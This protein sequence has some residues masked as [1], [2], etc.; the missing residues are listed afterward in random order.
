MIKLGN[1]K[2]DLYKGS[3]LI[4]KAY[5]GT[6]LIYNRTN[7]IELEY[8]E[9]TGT[10]F[11]DTG[12]T[13]SPS[14]GFWGEAEAR[15]TDGS[16]ETLAGY[17]TFFLPFAVVPSS[18]RVCMGYGD[19]TNAPTLYPLTDG[20]LITSTET[21]GVSSSLFIKYSGRF[22]VGLN[23]KGSKVWHFEDEKINFEIDLPTV[24]PVD[25]EHTMTVF[26]RKYDNNITTR[27]MWRG[28]I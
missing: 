9:S 19:N 1:Q 15:L 18:K 17:D 11:I 28:P 24:S 26:G 27:F 23:F 16:F 5:R 4:K 3:T 2:V 13:V 22:K 14:I 8:L 20:R 6:D 10:Q 21:S 25:T 7:H 12:L